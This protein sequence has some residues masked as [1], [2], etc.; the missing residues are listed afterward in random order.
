MVLLVVSHSSLLWRQ[1]EDGG[2]KRKITGMWWSR[3]P[4]LAG[5]VVCRDFDMKQVKKVIYNY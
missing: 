4:A 1:C 3:T 2:I 5:A